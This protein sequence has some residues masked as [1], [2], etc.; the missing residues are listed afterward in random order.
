MVSGIGIDMIE[1]DRV[2]EKIGKETGFRELV[3]STNE[4]KFCEAKAHKFEHYAARFAAK[5]AF[6]KAIGTGWTSGTAFNEIEI[7]TDGTGKPEFVFIGITAKTILAMNL[8]K[9]WVSLSHL[10]TIASAVVVI[11]K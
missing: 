6:L 9:V 7:S 10:K 4:I 2:A 5:E 3:F 8:K 11:E 1:V